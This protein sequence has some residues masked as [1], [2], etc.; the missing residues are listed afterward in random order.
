MNINILEKTMQDL[1]QAGKGILAADESAPTVKKRFDAV[2]V[3]CTEENRRLYRQ[4][5]FTAPQVEQYLSGIILFEETLN[6]KTDD[7]TP[8]PTYLTQHHIVPG[9]K[10]DKGLVALPNSSEEKVTDG[11]DGLAERLK[12][13]KTLGAR[14]AKWRIVISA[15]DMLPSHLAVKANAEVL[16]R[17]AAICQN[18]DIVPIV[19]PEVLM[20]GK[21]TIEQCAK[22]SETIQHALF[23]ALHRH[24]VQ[25]EYIILKPNMVISGKECPTQASVED[26]A[27]LTLQVLRRTVPAAVRSINFLSGGQTPELATAHLNRMHQLGFQPWNLSFSYAR[28]IQDPVLKTWATNIKNTT[29]AQQVLLN[30]VKLNSLATQGQYK[31]EMK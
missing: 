18:E 27:K 22:A 30:R 7:G 19:E 17:Y 24:H 12:V 21:H 5:L 15:G 4:L 6:Q 23:H 3:D 16:A 20:D 2:H 11:L 26:V 29:T 10:V 14:F 8:F 28:A 25:L 13:Y 1:V 9:I 31:T